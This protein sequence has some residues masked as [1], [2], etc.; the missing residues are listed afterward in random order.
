MGTQVIYLINFSHAFSRIFDCTLSTTLHYHFVHRLA[1]KILKTYSE[2]LF[3]AGSNDT[4]FSA[5]PI[6]EPSNHHLKTRKRS[7][8]SFASPETGRNCSNFFFLALNDDCSAQDRPRELKLLS[9]KPPGKKDSEY[10]FEI[11]F[12]VTVNNSNAKHLISS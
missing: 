4:N 7:R 12:S 11:I 5:R 9:L 8:R 10:V 1:R 2:S 3:P 6:S